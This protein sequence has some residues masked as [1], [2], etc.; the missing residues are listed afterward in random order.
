MLTDLG[1]T[2]SS[3]WQVAILEVCDLNAD[4]QSVVARESYWKD[5]LRSRQFEMNENF[6]LL[7]VTPKTV[8]HRKGIIR[9]STVDRGDNVIC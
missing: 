8:A 9:F 3:G 1:E 5:V 2:H 4:E 7:I 6:A